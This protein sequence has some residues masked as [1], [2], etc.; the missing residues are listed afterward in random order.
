MARTALGV[1]LLLAAWATGAWAQG[2]AEV[3]FQDPP[4][5]AVV[6]GGPWITVSGRARGPAGRPAGAFDVMLVI[7]TSGSTR[8]PSGLRVDRAGQFAT[9]TP[10]SGFGWLRGLGDS[11][12]AAEVGAAI[13]FLR[14]SDPATTRVGVITFAGAVQ[15][16]FFTGLAV[17][18]PG[19]TNAWV[20]QP[21][22]SDYEAVRRALLNVLRRGPEG[23]TDMGAGLRLAIREL[24]AVEGALSPPRL[25]ARK[26]ALLLTDGF[27]TLPFGSVDVM[28]PG[29][30]EVVVN[31]ARVAAKGGIAIHTFCLGPEALSAPIGCTEAARITSGIYTPVRTPADIV[32]IL[33]ATPIGHV[34]L[35]AVRN[36]TSGQMARSLSVA[37]DGAFTAE[38]PL[39][40]GAN[41][42]LVELH[43]SEGVWGSAAVVVH[44]RGGD[45]QV[46]VSKEPDRRV[47]I[48]VEPPAPRDRRFDVQVEPAPPGERRL[49][50]RIERPGPAR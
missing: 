6:E 2:A 27:P 7:D 14:I 37:A 4:E 50:L 28:D 23:G 47:D 24:L 35:V 11:I 22:T 15:F 29:D 26:V 3:F 16:Q 21:L 49:D 13:Q 9:A 48:Q 36:A 17:A 41:R 18:V 30:I 34:E 31:A 20:D 45:V 12:L 40:P 46:E 33:P 10:G 25:P 19:S 5:G 43:G 32:N 39:V 38:L 44:Y 8:N 42:L 1:M